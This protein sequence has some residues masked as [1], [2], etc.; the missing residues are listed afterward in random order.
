MTL[1]E[2][3]EIPKGPPAARFIC[4]AECPRC[5]KMCGLAKGIHGVTLEGRVSPS[6]VCPHKDCTFHDWVRL[7]GWLR[8]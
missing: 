2:R 1:I 8:H 5:K 7:E 4:Y 6:F 3:W